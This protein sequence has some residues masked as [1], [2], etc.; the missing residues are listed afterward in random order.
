MIGRN[1]FVSWAFVPS[2][3]KDTEDIYLLKNE[4]QYQKDIDFSTRLE[5]IETYGKEEKQIL[6]IEDTVLGPN[7][8][9]FITDSLTGGLVVSNHRKAILCSASLRSKMDLKF[10]HKLNVAKTAEDVR[11]A[12]YLQKHANLN[13]MVAFV[14]GAIGHFNTGR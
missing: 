14:D 10:Y 3:A 12:S 6:E 8:L 1:E 11:A 2:L 13:L 4:S 5:T 9:P 7:I